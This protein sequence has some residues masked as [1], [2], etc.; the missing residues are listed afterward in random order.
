MNKVA[1]KIDKILNELK[2][3]SDI[4]GTNKWGKGYIVRAIKLKDMSAHGGG[5]F[6]GVKNFVD[7]SRQFRTKG[8]AETFAKKLRA[9]YK[10]NKDMKVEVVNVEPGDRD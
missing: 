9:K 5:T 8:E 6:K 3:E 10:N 7:T 1:K 4:K 2:G